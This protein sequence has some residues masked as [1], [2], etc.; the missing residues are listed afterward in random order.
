MKTMIVFNPTAGQLRPGHQLEEV[1]QFLRQH[2]WE[3][4][5]RVTE[6]SGDATAFAQEAVEKKL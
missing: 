4:T 6:R 1:V 3:V 5:L 2:Q